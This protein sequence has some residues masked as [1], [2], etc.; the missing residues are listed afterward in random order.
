M[1]HTFYSLR[2][3]Y[4]KCSAGLPLDDILSLFIGVYEEL[5]QSGYFAEA[6]GYTCVDLGCIPGYVHDV[7]LEILLHIRKKDLW[8]PSTRWH[9]YSEDDFF[10]IIEFLFQHISK[11]IG[12][13]HHS[14][15]QCGMHWHTFD[16]KEGQ[17]FFRSRV[18]GILSHY[19]KAFELSEFGEIL[20]KPEHG[21]EGIFEAEIP[22]D[23]KKITERIDAAIIRY[24]RHGSTLDDRRQAVRDLADV[25]E[26]IRPQIKLTLTSADEKDLFSLANNFGIRHHNASQKTSYDASVWL[27]W[28]FYFYLST[29]HV[30]LRKKL[31]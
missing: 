24:R 21:F 11:P 7:D 31:L 2:N 22:A 20:H 27:S 4:N 14:Y 13:D 3:G 25:L 16:K 18:N 8:P 15:N 1:T 26:Y 5:G 12:G 23:D 17:V 30:V 9:D 6:F 10:D 19:E 29:I 28:M